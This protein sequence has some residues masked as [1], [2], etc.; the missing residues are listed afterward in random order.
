LYASNLRTGYDRYTAALLSCACLGSNETD[1]PNRSNFDKLKEWAATHAHP[2]EGL[3]LPRND[4]H[5]FTRLCS[6]VRFKGQSNGAATVCTIW[7]ARSNLDMQKD[8]T[9]GSYMRTPP[10]NVLLSRHT[11]RPCQRLRFQRDHWKAVADVR[12]SEAENVLGRHLETGL[13]HPVSTREAFSGTRYKQC[14]EDWE[15][16]FPCLGSHSR[17]RMPTLANGVLTRRCSEGGDSSYNLLDT[18]K[19]RQARFPTSNNSLY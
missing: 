16:V 4:Y 11:L 17:I 9:S 10:A 12:N 1:S 3:S 18:R 6:P 13:G 7:G 2:R 5:L 19:C 15:A 14:G 8:A